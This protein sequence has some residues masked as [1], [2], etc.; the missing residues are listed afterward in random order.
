MHW[1]TQI[2]GPIFGML[3]AVPFHLVSVY[4]PSRRGGS[5]VDGLPRRRGRKAKQATLDASRTL[6]GTLDGDTAGNGTLELQTGTLDNGTIN[7]FDN[8]TINTMGAETMNTMGAETMSSDAH[9]TI[10]SERVY[11]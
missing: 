4:E 6:E 3:F 11:S 2:F 10:E 9:L 7:T 1:C 8:G 5:R